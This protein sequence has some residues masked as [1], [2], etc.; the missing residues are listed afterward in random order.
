[1]IK[2]Y[3]PQGTTSNCYRKFLV[4]FSFT[5]LEQGSI[6]ESWEDSKEQNL[7]LTID[8]WHNR[9]SVGLSTRKLSG[10]NAP[11]IQESWSPFE[12]KSKKQVSRMSVQDVN[13]NFSGLKCR[14]L[15][16][17]AVDD[18]LA[19]ESGRSFPR[20]ATPTVTLALR[21]STTSQY[22]LYY[23]PVLSRG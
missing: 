18:S 16:R 3:R 17:L 6:L 10:Q 9:F 15:Q 14:D 5:Q 22:V 8:I 2:H 1:M 21:F 20:L 4:L 11:F 7:L 12:P 19:G 13:Y 23:L